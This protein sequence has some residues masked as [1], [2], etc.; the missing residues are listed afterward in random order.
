MVS[1]GLDDDPHERA[2][3]QVGWQH[4]GSD[5]CSPIEF[6][7]LQAVMTIDESTISGDGDRRHPIQDVDEAPNM[8]PVE[9]S[10]PWRVRPHVTDGHDYNACAIGGTARR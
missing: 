2:L 3:I 6:V 4:V 9:W 7:R 8:S 1:I 10:T 5:R